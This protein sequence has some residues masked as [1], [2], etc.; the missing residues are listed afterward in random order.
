MPHHIKIALPS[1]MEVKAGSQEPQIR[2]SFCIFAA[3]S[4]IVDKQDTD[5]TRFYVIIILIYNALE[6]M[7]CGPTYIH[8][9]YPV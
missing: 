6:A 4:I 5:T 9:W 2:G 1:D 3:K 7:T 8:C